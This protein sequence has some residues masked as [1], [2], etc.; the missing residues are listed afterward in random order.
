LGRPR[1]QLTEPMLTTLPPPAAAMPG[2]TDWMA[3]K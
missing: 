1:I 2:A 3:K